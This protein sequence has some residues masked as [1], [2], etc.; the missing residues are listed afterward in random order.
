[1]PC[2]SASSR[3]EVR[4]A[5]T[6]SMDCS[7]T[8]PPDSGSVRCVPGN[9]PVQG[10]LR[11]VILHDGNDSGVVHRFGRHPRATLF[12]TARDPGAGLRP[13]LGEPDQACPLLVAKILSGLPHGRRR[14]E[15]AGSWRRWPSHRTSPVR[16]WPWHP[17]TRQ[18]PNSMF[19]GLTAS[20]IRGTRIA[21]HVEP[22]MAE[23]WATTR[24]DGHS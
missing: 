4:R 11:K 2:R 24:S 10:T 16:L 14:A 8:T 21:G 22:R 12:R 6:S 9:L 13:V 1:M 17:S 15:P 5:A 20:L 3:S 19:S 7:T 23:G 18:V